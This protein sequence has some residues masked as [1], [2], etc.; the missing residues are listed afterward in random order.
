MLFFSNRADKAD[1]IIFYNE[2]FRKHGWVF[3]YESETPNHEGKYK[4]TARHHYLIYQ[5]KELVIHLSWVI[6]EHTTY[7]IKIEQR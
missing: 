4:P 3:T 6:T 7:F 2:E 1:I 5:K